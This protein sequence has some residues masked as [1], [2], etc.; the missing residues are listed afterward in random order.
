MIKKR[1]RKNILNNNDN[2]RLEMV[3][4]NPRIRWMR[5]RELNKMFSDE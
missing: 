1:I 5:D 4:K 3:S 2:R